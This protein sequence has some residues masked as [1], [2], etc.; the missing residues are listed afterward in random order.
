MAKHIS[1]IAI[2]VQWS[3]SSSPLT[4]HPSR[5]TGQVA[6]GL[7]PRDGAVTWLALP[8]GIAVR[9]T[10]SLSEDRWSRAKIQTDPAWYRDE[11]LS[12]SCE[13]DARATLCQRFFFFF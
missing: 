5:L 8:S 4:R 3:S 13:A 10:L 11:S 2:A 9:G 7:L 12:E 1:V 6:G